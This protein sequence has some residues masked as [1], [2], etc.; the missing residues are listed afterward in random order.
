MAYPYKWINK[1]T[2]LFSPQ[3]RVLCE[4]VGACAFPLAKELVEYKV[5][6]G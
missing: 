5:R 3:D 6:I 1:N 4:G 2:S